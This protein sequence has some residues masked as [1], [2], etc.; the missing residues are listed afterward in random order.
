MISIFMGAEKSNIRIMESP[1][2]GKT[3]YY[4]EAGETTR[5]LSEPY[6]SKVLEQ[7]QFVKD[8]ERWLKILESR[9]ENPIIEE[10]CQKIELLYELTKK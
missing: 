4:R 6:V 9:K 8:K 10:L 7:I 2:G 5:L 1:D 3:V